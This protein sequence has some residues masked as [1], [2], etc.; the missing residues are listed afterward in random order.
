LSAELSGD[1]IS[2][3]I[4]R[5][6][7]IKINPER[8]LLAQNEATTKLRNRQNE[9]LEIDVQEMAN[10]LTNLFNEFNTFNNLREELTSQVRNELS[11]WEEDNL[12]Y[13]IDPPVGRAEIDQSEEIIEG[14]MNGNK[15]V[16]DILECTKEV[17]NL[18]D[19]VQKAI[20]TI[21]NAKKHCLQ[22]VN[23]EV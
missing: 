11:G 7:E 15:I 14:L 2:Y 1:E 19:G 20:T 9:N 6:S 16:I 12:S 18:R 5:L 17:T 4:I 13:I 23:E 21:Q 3:P 8:A 22:S 10:L